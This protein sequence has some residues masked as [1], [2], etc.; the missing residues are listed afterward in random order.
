MNTEI[1]KKLLLISTQVYPCPPPAYS[2]I[3]YLVY[4]IACL[5]R[6]KG[7]KV[8]VATTE[9]SHIDGVECMPL[10]AALNSNPE[11]T[12]YEGIKP[13]LMQTGWD[14]IHG[15][16]HGGYEY[17]AKVENP[18][19]KVIHTMHNS[20][21]WATA[22]PIKKPNL[23]A[24]SKW[25]RDYVSG[26]LGVAPELCYN[27]INIQD[28]HPVPL[29]EKEDYILFMGRIT[30]YKGPHEVIRIARELG[31]KAIIAGEDVLVEDQRYVRRII[32]ECDGRQIKYL[33]RVN[34]NVKVELMQKAKVLLLPLLPEYYGCFELVI[35][36]ANACGCPVVATNRGAPKEL[37]D[38]GKSGFVVESVADMAKAV[39][40]ALELSPD[41]CR[42]QG[43]KFSQEI[44]GDRYEELYNRVL[45]GDCW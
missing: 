29:S 21:P 11:Q 6:D 44:M 4:Q 28:H 7:W 13:G 16:G 23:V 33:G 37:I 15:H 40:Y 39:R 8:W 27:G 17:L 26:T 18:A 14:I 35:T 10:T 36:E 2:G 38:E 20:R 5:M 9:G 42:A 45:Q 22:P 12:A 31:M 43:I 1:E 34:R 25:H 30:S 19:L 32:D 41:D 3:E 24:I